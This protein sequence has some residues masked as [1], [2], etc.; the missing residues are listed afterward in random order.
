MSFE[1]QI[2]YALLALGV[3]FLVWGLVI[4]VI[5]AFQ[6]NSD[7]EWGERYLLYDLGFIVMGVAFELSGLGLVV[8]G[9]K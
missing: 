4:A 7:R 2:K 3:A 8:L 9:K 1:R 6:M 5:Y